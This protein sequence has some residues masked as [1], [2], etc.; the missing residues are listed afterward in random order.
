MSGT[1][2]LATKA[3][4]VIRLVGHVP[5]K[6]AI[7]VEVPDQ[8][9]PAS[10][11]GVIVSRKDGGARRVYEVGGPSDWAFELETDL[12]GGYYGAT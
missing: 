4:E 10:L 11:L 6:F 1:H 2:P 3:R 5:D 8:G 7:A 9:S 12:K